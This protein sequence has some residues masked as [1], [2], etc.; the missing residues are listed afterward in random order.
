MFTEHAQCKDKLQRA[1]FNVS[2]PVHLHSQS[3]TVDNTST[4]TTFPEPASTVAHGLYRSSL[5]LTPF[6]S[7]LIEAS[8]IATTGFGHHTG[9]C[10][11]DLAHVSPQP[12][13]Q[14]QATALQAS[15]F[16]CADDGA[17]VLL[18]PSQFPTGVTDD[19]PAQTLATHSGLLLAFPDSGNPTAANPTAAQAS[20]GNVRTTHN[21]LPG[22]GS[23]QSIH[24]SESNPTMDG[25][26]PTLQPSSS[27]IS[28]GVG[29]EK[30]G[31]ASDEQNDTCSITGALSAETGKSTLFANCLC[32]WA[33]AASFC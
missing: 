31:H 24:N 30:A 4:S 18:P 29:L 25:D 14:S 1:A 17:A 13:E 6:Q 22:I 10:D 27:G 26:A 21:F 7:F 15:P 20:Q 16:G 3:A 2:S 8:D 33:V 9:S 11:L 12:S 23:N 28:Q 19:R 5:V 32:V